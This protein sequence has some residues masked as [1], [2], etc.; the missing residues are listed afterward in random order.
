MAPELARG[1]KDAK[2]SSDVWSFGV[3]AYELF[4]GRHPFPSPPAFDALAGRPI[5]PPA[6]LDVAG[7]AP[8]IA[9]LVGQCIS[10]DAAARPTAQ[11]LAEV[12]E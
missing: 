12:V 9:R 11:R 1:S 8:E 5:S 2:P 6:P 7:L 3:M 10:P 4:T